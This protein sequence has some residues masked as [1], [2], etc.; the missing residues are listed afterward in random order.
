MIH[1][2]TKAQREYILKLSETRGRQKPLRTPSPSWW[3]NIKR[4]VRR[5]L[6][7]IAFAL[8]LCL[9]T[10]SR[11]AQPQ[12]ESGDD[13]PGGSMLSPSMP[14]DQFK[15]QGPAPLFWPP[16]VGAPWWL[17]KPT[18]MP[19][20]EATVESLLESRLRDLDRKIEAGFEAQALAETEV[21]DRLSDMESDQDCIARRMEEMAGYNAQSMAE[22][23]AALEALRSVLNNGLTTLC[24]TLAAQHQGHI[25]RVDATA[26]TV[27]ALER[28]LAAVERH[29]IGLRG[30]VARSAAQRSEAERKRADREDVVLVI[31]GVL[32]AAASVLVAV[33][34]TT[35]VRRKLS[36]TPIP[37]VT[38]VNVSRTSPGLARRGLANGKSNS[39]GEA[40][41]RSGEVPVPNL[42]T[43]GKEA[44]ATVK[45]TL[46]P[47]RVGLATEKGH[48]RE[49]Q[50]DAGYA[51]VQ[52]G[53]AV[54]IVADGMGGLKHGRLAAVAASAGAARSVLTTLGG[55]AACIRLDPETIAL[56]ALGEG[57]RRLQTNA[58]RFGIPVSEC[59]S[60]LI[61][62]L[63][64]PE[65]REL[66]FAYIGDG[67][68][69][70]RRADGRIEHFLKPMKKPG[71]HAIWASLGPELDGAPVSGCMSLQ[72]GDL[73]VAGTDGSIDPFPDREGEVAEEL[74]STIAACGGDAQQGVQ[75]VVSRYINL[76]DGVGYFF[77]DNTTLGVIV[78]SASVG[79]DVGADEESVD[80]AI[81]VK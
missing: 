69:L 63:F 22:C 10:L 73:V 37:P 49:C 75:E 46:D 62:A 47:M 57:Q 8:S 43:L 26:Q 55:A 16:Y 33:A 79:T 24:Q 44:W 68:G 32:V 77:Q 42:A 59:R 40:R 71:D 27:A 25:D 56:A 78:V 18:A 52:N 34:Q 58:A 70:V 1:P 15:W 12:N 53:W 39:G 30:S 64:H 31:A 9:P 21:H 81:G 2:L 54:L 4:A 36:G 7:F 17:S 50:E 38:A 67:V 80:A 45:P 11:G 65:S 14:A 23:A 61:V 76:R 28:R 13:Q 29:L 74:A 60:T 72:A 19:P 3:T 66:G 48:V 5:R 20:V 51:F 35:L 6:W 41:T